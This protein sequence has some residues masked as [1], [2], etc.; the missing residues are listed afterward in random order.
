[1]SSA[2]ICACGPIR[3]PRRWRSRSRPPRSTTRSMGQNWE[4][5]AMIKARACGRRHRRRRGVSRPAA[6]LYLAQVSRLRRDC[7]HA[8]DE[9]ADPRG[10]GPW[11]DRGRWATTSSSG[12]GGIRE[13]EF[14]V[15]TQQLIAGGRNPKL[16]GREHARHARRR[17]PRPTGSR[18]RPR[19]TER[20]P[21]ASC[22]TIEHRVQMV[23]D[24]Q[25][26]ALPADDRQFEALA[27]FCG[28]DSATALR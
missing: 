15:Q 1:M 11:R 12:R 13:I 21:I 19:R 3:A 5:A 7:R 14:F 4:R 28:F 17:W 9:A 22:A 18:R 6:A 27:R 10:E 25:T 23:N 16:R 20:R 26:H 2:P 24:E 8:F